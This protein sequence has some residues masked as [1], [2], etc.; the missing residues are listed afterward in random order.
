MSGGLNAGVFEMIVARRKGGVRRCCSVAGETTDL[1]QDFLPPSYFSHVALP[2]GFRIHGL[3][4][5]DVYIQQ[6]LKIANKTNHTTQHVL[7]HKE[8]IEHNDNTVYICTDERRTMGS[9]LH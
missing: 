2:P 4:S 5:D 6:N 1:G 8:P 7:G 9:N 3:F